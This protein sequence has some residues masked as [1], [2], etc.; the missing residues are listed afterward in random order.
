VFIKTKKDKEDDM[1]PIVPEEKEPEVN[2]EIDDLEFE[3]DISEEKDDIQVVDT[4]DNNIAFIPK[5]NYKFRISSPYLPH[6]FE[7]FQTKYPE[8]FATVSRFHLPIVR[9]YY[10]G[11]T[12]YMLPSCISACMQIC[13]YIYQ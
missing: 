13:T 5:I 12:V 10:D 4:P 9:S 7:L 1:K 8:F 3:K 2:I 11:N 6:N